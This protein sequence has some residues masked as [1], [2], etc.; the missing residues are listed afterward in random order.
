[1]KDVVAAAGA[2]PATRAAA[3]VST[4]PPL[5]VFPQPVDLLRTDDLVF[6]HCSFVNLTWGTTQAGQ[7]PFLVRRTKNRPAFL[8]VGFPPQHVIERA[9]FQ[10]AAGLAPGATN[11]PG[12]ADPDASKGGDDPL[13]VPPV[14]ASLAASSRLVF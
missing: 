1:M 4:V 3:S 2:G 9:F 7:P 11:P 8:V 14:F 6:L 12:K 10:T 13:E 5:V